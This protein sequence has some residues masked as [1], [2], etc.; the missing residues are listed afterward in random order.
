MCLLF[1]SLRVSITLLTNA[2]F[3]MTLITAFNEGET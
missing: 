1:K 2:A 3:E